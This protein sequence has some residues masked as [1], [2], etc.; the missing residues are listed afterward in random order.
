MMEMK[1]TIISF[2][3][4]GALFISS[5]S[6]CN[7]GGAQSDRTGAEELTPVQATGLSNATAIAGGEDH[8]IAL[9]QD[10]SV[11]AWGNNELGQL[12]DGS[13]GVNNY[14]STPVQVTGLA[15]IT[16][17]AGGE[18]HTVAL[19]QDGSLWAWGDNE[20]GQ[21][22]D[23]TSGADNY[24]TTPVQVAGLSNVTAIA[25]GEDHT[26]ALKQDGSVW[27]WGDNEHGQ[28]GDGTSGIDNYRSTPGQVTGISNVTAVA[29]R[30]DHTIALK[31]DGSVWAWGNNEHGQIGDGTGGNA[32]RPTP[33]Q[34]TGLADIT[35]IAGGEDHTIALKQ[36]GSVWIWGWN[37]YGQLGDGTSGSD[38][39]R[40]TPV[41]VAGLSN[42][43]AI[44][45][46]EDHTIALK[47]DGSV[48]VWGNNEHGQLGDGTS[49][50]DNY[51]ATP[52]QVTGISNVTAIAGG[53][54]HTIVLKQDGSV[55]A[56]GDNDKGQIGAGY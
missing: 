20:H 37:I 6:G 27:A 1:K 18:H 24:R 45:G 56:W 21:L 22:G 17:I 23:G 43:T 32:N 29:G 41:Q 54:D 3:M 36:D 10:G 14:R 42:V 52:W 2:I 19:M 49:G 30:G 15:N 48:W 44:A 33:V 13:S 25:G 28:L 34:V 26:I 50:V 31:Q 40:A 5:V 7:G 35:A 46:G 4:L 8:T 38:N 55:W 12:G 39:Y 9:R 47:Q 11:W 51:R 53:G 16:A